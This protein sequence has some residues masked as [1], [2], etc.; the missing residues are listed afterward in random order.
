MQTLFRIAR[1]LATYL[2]SCLLLYLSGYGK[3]MEN[4]HPSDAMRVFLLSSLVISIIIFL[5][6]EM[7]L[8]ARKRIKELSE[9][10]SE[11]ENSNNDN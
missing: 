10:I 7:C 1:F 4:I 9:R 8:F 2:I 11:L 3:L 5:I 6:L